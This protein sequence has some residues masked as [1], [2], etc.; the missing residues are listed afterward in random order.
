MKKAVLLSPDR[1]YAGDYPYSEDVEL[2]ALASGLW[3]RELPPQGMHQ[4]TYQGG[5]VATVPEVSTVEPTEPTEPTEPAAPVYYGEVTNGEWVDLAAPTEAERLAVEKAV[6]D[7]AV[8]VERDRRIAAGVLFN[9]VL[10]Q[11]RATDRENIAGAAQLALMATLRGEG[12]EG[13]FLWHGGEEPFAWIA[14]DNSLVQMDAPTVIA[15][16]KTS[17]A[18]KQAYTMVARAIKD[19]DP[20]PA[21]IKDDAL[22]TLPQ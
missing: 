17:A 7:A 16:A 15:F 2:I 20:F 11:S 3:T 5:E 14:A 9:G 6:R 18:M 1:T 4:P 13:N 19:M 10:F 12:E 22:W 21:D 8:T